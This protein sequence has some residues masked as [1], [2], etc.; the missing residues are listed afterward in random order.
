MHTSTRTLDDVLEPL[1]KVLHERKRPEDLGL[2]ETLERRRLRL[3]T[4]ADIDLSAT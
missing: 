1:K 2:T 3:P 4:A